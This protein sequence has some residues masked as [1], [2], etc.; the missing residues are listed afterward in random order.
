MRLGGLSTSSG[1][2]TRMQREATDLA[3]IALGCIRIG[4]DR[5]QRRHLAPGLRTGSDAVGDRTH[6]QRF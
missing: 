1:Q 6:P 5:L 3:G 2:A 4:W